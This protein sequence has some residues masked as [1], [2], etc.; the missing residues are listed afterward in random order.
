MAKE[1]AA[2]ANEPDYALAASILK[3][4]LGGL[5]DDSSKLNGQLSAAWKRVEKEAGV[6]R[7]AAKAVF[8]LIHKSESAQNDYM[9]TFL[10][11]AEQFKLYPLRKDL[12]DKAE[13]GDEGEDGE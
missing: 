9:R 13:A 1:N 2:K 4:T 11:M 6:H 7:G 10:G 8:S 12:V 5:R 3:D